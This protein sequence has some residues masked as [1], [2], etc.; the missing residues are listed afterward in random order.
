V[1]EQRRTLMKLSP[2][3]RKLW[4]DTEA[5]Y[6]S[7]AAMSTREGFNGLRSRLHRL[8][9]NQKRYY[10]RLVRLNAERFYRATL[11]T[12]DLDEFAEQLEQMNAAELLAMVEQMRLLVDEQLGP[13][14]AEEDEA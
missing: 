9:N 1:N 10:R 3:T 6:R 12:M 7:P 14:E 8:P 5:I 4:Q 2:E 13:D 11:L